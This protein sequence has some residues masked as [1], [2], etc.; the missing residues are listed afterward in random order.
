MFFRFMV[1]GL[2]SLY[3]DTNFC[4]YVKR[5]LGVLNNCDQLFSAWVWKFLYSVC[6]ASVRK[7]CMS[8]YVLYFSMT[9]LG[10][11]FNGSIECSHNLNDFL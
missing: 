11:L 4:D 3:K 6:F 8:K 7:H 10:C 9:S 1:M 2:A 5:T